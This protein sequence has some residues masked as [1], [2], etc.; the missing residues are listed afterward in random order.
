MSDADDDFARS[1]GAAIGPESL[2]WQHLSGDQGRRDRGAWAM[3]ALDFDLVPPGGIGRWRPVGPAPITT[4][5]EQMFV[6]PG[7]VAGQVRDLA[8]DPRA[9]DAPTLYAACNSAGVWKSSDGGASWQVLNDQL[10]SLRIGAVALDPDDP[11]TVYAGSGNL[12]D[13][14]VGERR[15]AG[16]FRSTDA[17]RNWAAMDGGPAASR[18]VGNGIH[19]IVAL[20]GGRLAVATAQ[21]LLLSTNGGMSFERQPLHNGFIGQVSLDSSQR[22]VRRVREV[23]ATAGAP[24]TPSSSAAC[25]P[26]PG[27]TAGASCA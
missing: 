17:G 12:F 3:G 2:D 7:P 23:S 10:P 13:G 8:I 19:R 1:V 20:G 14:S 4:R 27:R 22:S 9:A 6:G 26:A 11:D 24:T 5:N 18:L 15:G 16:L 21:N 25:P